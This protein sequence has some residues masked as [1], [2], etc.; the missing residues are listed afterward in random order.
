MNRLQQLFSK[1]TSQILNI[2]FTA[3]YPKLHDTMPI[4]EALQEAGADMVEIGMPFSDPLAD[5]ETIQQSSLQALEN[6]MKLTVLFEQLAEMRQ[7][8]Q[9]PVVLMGYLNPVLQFG[10][11][12]FCQQ[13][14][15][16]GVDA[17]ILPDLPLAEYEAL[18]RPTFQKYGLENIFLITPQT[19]EERIRMIDQ[20]SEAFIYMVSSASTTGTRQG[21]SEEQEAY[22]KRIQAMQLKN[23]C[24]IGFGISDAASFQTASR[25]S[26]GAII[27]SAFIKHLGKSSNA[28]EAAKQFVQGILQPAAEV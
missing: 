10:I 1:K 4:L 2:Y 5:G 9:L 8:I 13:C 7:R 25:Y 15:A 28:A 27:G 16:V 24:L 19:K 23:P 21:I 26:Q 20:L 12:K 11:E 3:G 14:Q 17:L 6:G 22:F 18:Y